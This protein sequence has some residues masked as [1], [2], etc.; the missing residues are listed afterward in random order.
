MER[1]ER[2]RGRWKRGGEG[3]GGRNTLN[4]LLLPSFTLGE[5]VESHF[6]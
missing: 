1:T 3:E 5:T 2:I 6:S 4:G